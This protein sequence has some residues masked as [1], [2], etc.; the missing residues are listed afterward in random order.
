[1]L[2]VEQKQLYENQGYL[3]LPELFNA[4]QISA[5][6][7]AAMR[8]VDEFDPESTRSIFSTEN[9]DTNRDQYFLTSDDKVRC[10][11]EEDAFN[12]DGEL[13]QEKQLSINKIGHAL[14]MLVPE[15]KQF[16]SADIIKQIAMDLGVESPEIRQSMYI[17]K[18]P[19]I[20][21]VVR[22][23]QDATYFYT[24]PLSVVTF[25]FAIEDATLENG[26]LQVAPD[27]ANF[28]LKEQFKRYPDDTTGLEQLEDIEWP[29]ESVATPVEVKAG[30]L[31]VFNGVLPHFSAANRSAKSR[32]A[33]TLHITS[34]NT[35]YSEFN[36]LKAAPLSL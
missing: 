31:V 26:C 18:Q 29:D 36:W 4:N 24:S 9:A 10:F 19:K 16:A 3:V 15:F 30:S 8:I 25:W 6:K 5:L 12:A 34:A 22:W 13:C 27:G 23:H 7:T 21:G 20:G 17:F 28:P 11:F 14:H 1:M 32:H 35:H 2:S 33:F